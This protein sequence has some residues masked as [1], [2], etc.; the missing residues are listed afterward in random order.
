[1]RIILIYIFFNWGVIYSQTSVT[2]DS[3]IKNR[4]S[5]LDSSVFKKFNTINP[6]LLNVYHRMDSIKYDYCFIKVTIN[7]FDSTL[8][9][10]EKYFIAT[11]SLPTSFF[12]N[13]EK[14][15]SKLFYENNLKIHK[16]HAQKNFKLNRLLKKYY[17]LKKIQTI[18]YEK[19]QIWYNIYLI[20]VSKEEK[21]IA[22]RKQELRETYQIQI[23]IDNVNNKKVISLQIPAKNPKFK[24]YGFNISRLL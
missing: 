5:V 8:D 21:F 17:H 11:D 14:Y 10:T 4:T 13:D 22:I 20:Y 12:I 24:V 18:P 3:L 15:D 1:M 6:E 2:I 23:L 7:D 16:E 9:I 19:T